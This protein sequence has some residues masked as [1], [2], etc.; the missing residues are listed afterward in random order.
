MPEGADALYE[1][2]QVETRF[3]EP[4]TPPEPEQLDLGSDEFNWLEDALYW[5]LGLDAYAEA[6]AAN[7]RDYD[8]INFSEDIQGD[9]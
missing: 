5:L 4:V 1:A 7:Q 6:D 8:E 9:Y 2:S 3:D